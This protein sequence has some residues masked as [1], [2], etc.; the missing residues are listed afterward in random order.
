M[1]PPTIPE[2]IRTD[3]A[4]GDPL[5][6]RYYDTE[7]GMPVTDEQGL[8]ERVSLEAFQAGLSWLTILR[9]R[10]AFRAAFHD[11]DPDRVAAYGEKDIERLLANAAIVRNVAKIQATVTNAQAVLALRESGGLASLIWAHQPKT[12]PRPEHPSEVPTRSAESEALA[13]DLKAH[14]FTFI[15]PT[16]AHALMEAV[17]VVDTHILASHRRGCSGLWNPDGS[18]KQ[19]PAH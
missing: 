17:G 7:W 13:A 10:E 2:P 14:G 9:K 16:T 18:R 4:N 3:W 1:A 8:F 6:T 12:T 5:L 19:K 11:F 15:G